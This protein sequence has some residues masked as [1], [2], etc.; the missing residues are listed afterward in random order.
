M[1]EVRMAGEK[2]LPT[3]RKIT[4]RGSGESLGSLQRH[5]ETHTDWRDGFREGLGAFRLAPKVGDIDWS[6]REIDSDGRVKV[7][8]TDAIYGVSQPELQAEYECLASRR[9]KQQHSRK[10]I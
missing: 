2:L 8:A 1:S 4:E 10:R 3:Q 9:I 6:T 5:A 7:N